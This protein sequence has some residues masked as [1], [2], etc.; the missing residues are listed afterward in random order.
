MS[1]RPARS[2]PAL[3][4]LSAV[5]VGGLCGGVATFTILRFVTPTATPLLA[6]TTS[7]GLPAEPEADWCAPQFEPIAGGGCYAAPPFAALGGL[8]LLIYLH[9]RFDRGLAAEGTGRQR[10]LAA[11]ATSPG[12]AVLAL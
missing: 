10:R 5:L 9:G 6:V 8:P 1:Q 4:A 12:V 11:R 3:R 2:R 7:T